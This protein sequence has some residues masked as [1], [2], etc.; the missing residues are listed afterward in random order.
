MLKETHK[1][2]IFR[3]PVVEYPNYEVKDTAVAV[4]IPLF[5][6]DID[7][8][9]L[10]DASAERL[11]DIHA[12]GAIWAAMSLVYNTDLAD[13]GVGIYF[14][15]EDCILETVM[16]VFEAFKV[17][18]EYI[19]SICIDAPELPRTIEHPIYGKK[20]MCIEDPRVQTERWLIMDSDMFAC[21]AEKKLS[22]Y[23]SLKVFQ[24]PSALRSQKSDYQEDYE[25]WVFG[26]C[27]AAGL[28]FFREDPLFAQEIRAF[29]T[30]GLWTAPYRIPSDMKT[31]PYISTQMFLLPMRH[32]ILSFIR[33]SYKTCYQD[34]FL[35]GMWNMTYDYQISDLREKAGL[36]NVYQFETAYRHRNKKTDIDG[37][38]AHIVPDDHG[39][40]IRDLDAYYDDFFQ[41]LQPKE[42]VGG[43]G[44]QKRNRI[45]LSEQFQKTNTDKHHRLGHQYGHFYDMLFESMVYR[46]QRGLRICEIGV[47][48]FGRG[49]MDAFQEIDAIDQ[50]IGIDIMEYLGTLGEKAAFHKAD[51]Y[52]V[53][54]VE[55]LKA[56]YPEGFDIII[57]D[58]T[59]KAPDQRF[60]FE[61]YGQLLT[62]GGKLVCEDVVDAAF[63]KQACHELN[64]YGIDGW[65]NIGSVVEP[66][67]PHQE[68]ILIRDQEQCSVPPEPRRIPTVES[69]PV[70]DAATDVL[71]SAETPKAEVSD[72]KDETISSYFDFTKA[73]FTEYTP[74]AKKR[75]IVLDVPYAHSGFIACAFCQRVQM[76]CKMM[77]N[78][79]HEIIYI[80]HE[81]REIACTQRY[82]IITDEILEKSYGSSDYMA[83]PE[84]SEDD[85]AFKEFEKHA[86]EIIRDIAQ[87]DDFVLAF[88]GYGHFDL[89]QAI[90]DLPVIIVEPSIG[91]TDVFTS[92]KVYQSVGKMHFERGKADVNAYLQR[93]YPDHPYNETYMAKMNRLPYTFADRNSCV[94][95]NFFDFDDFQDPSIPREDRMCFLGRISP[96]KG[97]FDA[98][99]L[100]AY[101]NTELLVAGVGHLDDL[102]FDVPKQVEF[103]GAVDPKNRNKVFWSSRV[104]VCPSIYIEPFLGAGVQSL[105]C[106]LPHI[107]SNWGASMDWCI[108]G[109]TG[110]RVQNFDQMLWAYKNIHRISGKNC[111]Y[112]A[113]Q[114][115]KE[116]AAISYHEYF[117]MLLQNKNGGYLSVNPERTNL[118]WL[119]AEM[120]EQEILDATVEIQRS[121]ACEG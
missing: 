40:E 51:A 35:L 82:G 84:H 77:L 36:R 21:S 71:T 116:R 31:R 17:P 27:L 72:Q 18:S 44:R 107:V 53:E 15:I 111:R 62:E 64:C 121:I 4:S 90:S 14:H 108:H 117:N 73:K 120:T 24:K 2:H 99:K 50:V 95:P 54:T 49:S 76:W 26:A 16:P 97:I 1:P 6:S 66:V 89:C 87:A 83:F 52:D 41:H 109:K 118:H 96:A 67:Q 85:L 45:L 61:Q 38:L 80:G 5:H 28:P 110:Y 58:G 9:T 8:A 12:K 114:Y 65:A 78:L 113:I 70:S 101:T 81:K 47:S 91:Y 105:F 103:V 33:A 106:E 59:H 48:L 39:K 75:F 98:F 55:M 104:H 115:S 19:R 56:E 42:I 92:N 32:D 7:S 57:D 74:P 79:G 46:K 13:R 63:F 11:R 93:E 3:L 23:D 29:Y 102:P 112:Q 94:I 68:R 34:E 43:K 20:F 60:F 30:L 25:R 119:Q 69:A 86:A 37:Y 10:T 88:Y 22:L 100:A